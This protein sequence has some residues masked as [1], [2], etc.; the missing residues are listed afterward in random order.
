MKVI[1]AVRLPISA[2]WVICALS[3]DGVFFFGLSAF[4]HSALTT[5]GFFVCGLV[6]VHS[7]TYILREVTKLK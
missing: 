3:F 7:V 5:L 6:A 2:V 1:R 4:P